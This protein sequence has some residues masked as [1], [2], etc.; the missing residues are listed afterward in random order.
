MRRRTL[1]V[2]P[3]ELDADALESAV[4]RHAGDD[5]ET[6][7]VVPAAKVSRLQ[8]LTNEDDAARAE[9]EEAARATERATGEGT[10]AVASGESDPVQAVEDA[11][12]TF[13]ADEIVVV[14]QPDGDAQWLEGGSAAEA[15]RRFDLPVIHLVASADDG[16]PHEAG[17]E[18]VRPY[19]ESHELAR[20]AAEDTPV[21]LLGRV[22]GL[23]W[24]VAAVIAGL[25]LLLYWL[26]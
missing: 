4:H 3:A 2:T 8:W 15:L 19:S 25:L 21:S 17:A 11:L 16:R 22:A 26:L 1:V 5:A 7:V 18:S 23:V 20:G 13:G 14:T 9:A 10:A 24:A 6:L 12:R